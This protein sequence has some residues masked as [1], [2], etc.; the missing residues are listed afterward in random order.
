MTPSTSTAPRARVAPGACLALALFSASA[1]TPA[2]SVVYTQRNGGNLAGCG[3]LVGGPSV[4]NR[5]LTPDPT[6]DSISVSDPGGS[7]LPASAATARLDALP[8]TG[9]ISLQ[10][11]GSAQR[12]A[13]AGTTITAVSD[14]RDVWQFTLSVP[15]RFTLH[16]SLGTAS[17]EATMPPSHFT[18]A[19]P[20]VPDP[21]SPPLPYQHT[22][23]APGSFSL[24]ATGT[25]LPGNFIIT[26]FG[27]AESQASPFSMSFANSFS[28][29]FQ[30]AAQATSRQVTGNP[31]SFTSGV[32]VLGQVWN[33]AVDVGSTGHTSAVVFAS[34]APAQIQ[35]APGLTLLLGGTVLEF[36]PVAPGPVAAYGF[37]MPANPALAG[38]RLFTQAVHFGGAPSLRLSNS[39]DLTLGL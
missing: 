23:Q 14:S 27:R 21:G 22:L 5:F 3:Q 6:N 28:L 34:F 31:N 17:T 24:A 12:T 16:A 7:G 11:A 37:A 32:P 38:A 39:R 4:W 10:V 1:A 35:I 33:A 20:I 18:F 19:G 36:L 29:T 30:P 25:L 15:M 2:Q 13:P 26:L 8:S 9:G